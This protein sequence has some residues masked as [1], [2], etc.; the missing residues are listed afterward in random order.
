MYASWVLGEKVS[1]TPDEI[2]SSGVSRIL[3]EQTLG[4]TVVDK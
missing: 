3:P 1:W 2:L 4:P